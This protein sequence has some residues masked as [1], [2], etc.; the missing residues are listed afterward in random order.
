MPEKDPII[1]AVDRAWKFAE[2]LHV[3]MTC[4][5]S[6][7]PFP[8]RILIPSFKVDPESELSM[9]EV[10]EQMGMKEMP[11]IKKATGKQVCQ[12]CGRRMVVD[13][14]LRFHG[15]HW[16]CSVCYDFESEADNLRQL[17]KHLK[18]G[19]HTIRDYA[20]SASKNAVHPEKIYFD[21]IKGVA[22]RYLQGADKL[23][24]F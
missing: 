6:R 19:L 12:C 13:E 17:I 3:G 1:A 15:G 21:D 22:E 18:G 24:D 14:V 7:P 11:V 10:R 20:I 23:G 16:L 4:H 5:S 2:A 8:D 9:D